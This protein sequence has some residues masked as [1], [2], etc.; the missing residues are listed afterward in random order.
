MP[1]KNV[2][3]KAKGFKAWRDMLR[4]FTEETETWLSDYHSR[5]IA[6]TVSS[7]MKRVN[8]TP[9]RKILLMRGVVEILARICVYNLRQ[10]TYLTDPQ[11]PTRVNQILG[12][13]KTIRH[14]WSHKARGNGNHLLRVTPHSCPN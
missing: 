5:L 3:M 9:L 1:K 2:S 4:E 8:L 7:T 14:F 6:E 12:A 11:H 10:L 13:K